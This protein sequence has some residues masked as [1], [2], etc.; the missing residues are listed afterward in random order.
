[1]AKEHDTIWVFNEGKLIENKHNAITPQTLRSKHSRMC[2]FLELPLILDLYPSHILYHSNVK[3]LCLHQLDS[4]TKKFGN[5]LKE[6]F[7]FYSN[8]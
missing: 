4:I 5:H 3:T 7:Q 6:A 8:S 1:M 2:M